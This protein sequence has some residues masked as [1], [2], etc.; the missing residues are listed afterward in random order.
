MTCK[1]KN[2]SHRGGVGVGVECCVTCSATGSGTTSS[3]VMKNKL[4][5]VGPKNAPSISALHRITLH[6]IALEQGEEMEGDE[7]GEKCNEE[8]K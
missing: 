5:K 8:M 1:Q 6:C 7:K 4:G 2:V 3:Y